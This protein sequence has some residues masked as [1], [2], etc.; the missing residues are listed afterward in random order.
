MH[1]F[2]PEEIDDILEN[3]FNLYKDNNRAKVS[4]IELLS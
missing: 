2:F 1:N 4:L 3:I